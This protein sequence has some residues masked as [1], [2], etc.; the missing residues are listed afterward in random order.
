M[1]N[2]ATWVDLNTSL[3]TFEGIKCPRQGHLLRADTQQ[4]RDRFDSNSL[5]TFGF[6]LPTNTNINKK[7]FMS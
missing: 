7:H 1:P 2:Y 6:L 4:S 3:A 5:H